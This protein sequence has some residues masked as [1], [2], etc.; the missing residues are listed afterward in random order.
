M[1]R[2]R[3][4]FAALAVGV[5]S[6]L[7]HAQVFHNEAVNGDLSNDR[8]NPTAYTLAAGTGSLMATTSGGDLEY[9]ALTI[10][11]G[12]KLAG[13]TLASYQG[14]DP[15]AF[16]GV[17][18]GST[19]TEPPGTPNVANILGYTHFGPAFV[20]MDILDDMGQGF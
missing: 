3:C 8:F 6:P 10:P 11:S 14:L 1:T 15:T 20:G 4:V 16:I 19:F 5:G 18:A 13:I 2:S 7:V 12:L 9:L 17:Q